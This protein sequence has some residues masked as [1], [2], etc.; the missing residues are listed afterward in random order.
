MTALAFT[1]TLI[2]FIGLGIY[3]SRHGWKIMPRYIRAVYWY[4]AHWAAYARAVETGYVEYLGQLETTDLKP[5]A[6]FCA[7][8]PPPPPLNPEEQWKEFIGNHVWDG[9]KW[10]KTPRHDAF[11][12]VK[13]DG[14]F[15]GGFAASRCRNDPATD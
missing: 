1:V 4:A 7:V 6:R 12:A 5:L 13:D 14:E 11:Q 3:A 2:F 9:G 10:V 15:D 8:S